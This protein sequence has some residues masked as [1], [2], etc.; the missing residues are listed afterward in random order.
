[1]IGA[2]TVDPGVHIGF[3]DKEARFDLSIRL[4]NT[5]GFPKKPALPFDLGFRAT[6]R[7]VLVGAEG[8]IHVG[9][10]SGGLPGDGVGLL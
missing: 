4:G 1:M 6:R 7:S 3:F 10:S 8:R 9:Q 5:L 2:E